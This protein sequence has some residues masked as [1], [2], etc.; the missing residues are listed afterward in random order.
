MEVRSCETPGQ[1]ADNDFQFG[2]D[3][4]QGLHCPYGAHIRRSN[5]RDSFHPG[6]ADQIDISNRHRIVRVGR[7]YVV[8]D[9]GPGAD[10]KGLLFMCLNSDI[11]RQFEFVQ[12]T[13]M[14]APSFHGLRCEVD[15]IVAATRNAGEATFTIPT[16]TGPVLVRDLKSFVTVRGGGYFFLP[17]RRALIF[18]AQTPPIQAPAPRRSLR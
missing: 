1:K 4:P 7:P 9:D 13:W 6:S 14:L 8:G 5:P 17:S 11:E 2:V 15:P 16:P 18:L 3:D 12:Q 10:A